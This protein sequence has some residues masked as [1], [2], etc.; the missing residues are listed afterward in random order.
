MTWRGSSKEAAIKSWQTRKL[1]SR[2][3]DKTL[4]KKMSGEVVAR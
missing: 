4:R 2:G 1:Q 3:F